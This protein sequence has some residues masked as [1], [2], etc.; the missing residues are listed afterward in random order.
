MLFSRLATVALLGLSTSVLAAPAKSFDRQLVKRQ[1]TADQAASA[2][3]TLTSQIQSAKDELTS[4]LADV[5]TSNATAVYAVAKPIL[6]EV[7]SDIKAVGTDLN[8][9]K[10]FLV[11]RQD[12]SSNSTEA[13]AEAIANAITALVDLLQPLEDLIESNPVLGA[14]LSPLFSNLSVDLVYVLSGLFL[15]LNGVL[16]LVANLLSGLGSALSGLGLGGL[17]SALGL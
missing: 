11:I 3:N 10:R 9:S 6:E 8:L 5:D 7:D 15:V 12:N 13:A 14:L 1:V 16:D 4:A 17:T 2:F